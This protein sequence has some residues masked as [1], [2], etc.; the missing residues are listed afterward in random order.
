MSHRFYTFTYYPRKQ[1]ALDWS[2]HEWC[3]YAIYQPETC[4]STGKLHYQ[5]YAEFC[6]P[7]RPASI[8]KLFKGIHCEPKYAESTRLEARGYCE[9]SETKIGDPVVYGTWEEKGQGSRSDLIEAIATIR[10]H[11]IKRCAEE[12]PTQFVRYHKGLISYSQVMQKIEIEKPEIELFPWQ[13]E[14]LQILEGPV[15]HRKIYWIWSYNPEAGKTTFS[16]YVAAHFGLDVFL[17]GTFE[18]KE[19]LYLYQKHKIIWFNIPRETPVDAR[20]SSILEDLSDGGIHNST[21]YE[22]VVK[23][24]KAHIVVTCNRPPPNNR[25]P[26][27][28]VEFNVDNK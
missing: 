4:P 18:F 2:R 14:V 23:Y 22:P 7:V 8:K 28:C 21:K 5:G 13:Q 6:R 11:G 19:L 27:R 12:H 26:N 3:R 15:I 17:K 16:H 24:I 20:L 10:D 1:E 25:L 9:K